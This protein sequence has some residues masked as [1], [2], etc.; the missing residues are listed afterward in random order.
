MSFFSSCGVYGED[1]VETDSFCTDN[2]YYYARIINKGEFVT[3]PAI[4]QNYEN[5][6]IIN[7]SGDRGSITI[8]GDIVASTEFG[9]EDFSECESQVCYEDGTCYCEV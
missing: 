5:P 7:V 9:V 3:E 4:V 2:F 6:E 8:E 1:A